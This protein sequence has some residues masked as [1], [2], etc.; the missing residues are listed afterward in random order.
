MYG[1]LYD[2]DYDDDDDDD[3]DDD[4]CCGHVGV[5]PLDGDIVPVEDDE[6]NGGGG[7]DQGGLA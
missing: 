7:Y 4:G 6:D 5:F 2:S 1:D 3:D